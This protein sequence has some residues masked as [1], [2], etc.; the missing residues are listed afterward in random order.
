M[1]SVAVRAVNGNRLSPSNSPEGAG[2]IAVIPITIIN[3]AISQMTEE[4]ASK[5]SQVSVVGR[6]MTPS[7]K[8]PGVCDLRGGGTRQM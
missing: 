3:I 5:L 8:E 6:A 7:P 4:M 1:L 2:T